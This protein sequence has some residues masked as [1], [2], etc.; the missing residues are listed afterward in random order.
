MKNVKIE[1][2]NTF[3]IDTIHF[4]VKEDKSIKSGVENKILKK[5]VDEK[6]IYGAISMPSNISMLF[7][8][9]SKI[10]IK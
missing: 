2:L 5:I 10:L 3:I 7:F 8:D 1:I 4:N 9:D 6:M